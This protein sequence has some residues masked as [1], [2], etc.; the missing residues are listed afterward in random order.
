MENHLI[1]QIN[2]TTNTI[3]TIAGDVNGGYVDGIGIFAAF[4]GPSHVYVNP[5]GTMMYVA[6]HTNNFIRQ[7]SCL[8]GGK[9][10]FQFSY[11]FTLDWHEIL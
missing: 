10:W 1:R 11:M 5:S 6:D 9:L 3:V 8:S 4:T 2:F 7:I